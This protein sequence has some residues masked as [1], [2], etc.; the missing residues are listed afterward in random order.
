VLDAR[1]STV[2]EPQWLGVSA[3][4]MG[5]VGIGLL[6]PVAPQLAL[7]GVFAAGFAA[8]ALFNLGAALA[9]FVVLTFFDRTT[10]LQSM[11]LTT[12]VKLGGAVIAAVWLF[13]LLD[14]RTKMRFIFADHPLVAWSAIA[15]VAFAAASMLWATESGAAFSSAF[16]LVQ[17]VLLLVITYSV[18]S[19][20][21]RLS[22]VLGAFVA[23]SLFAAMLGFF[24][25][26]SADASVND[27]RLSGGFDDPNELAAVVVPSMVFCA[28]GFTALGDRLIRWALVPI[29]MLLGVVLLRTDSQAGLV[30]L[31]VALLLALVFSGDL[32]RRAAVVVGTVVVAGTLFYTLV[33]APVAFQTILSPDNTSN[34]ESLWTV[35]GTM[36]SDQP[37]LGVGAG[38]FSVVEPFYTVRAIN[39][40]RV[41]LISEG[42]LV[43]NSYLQVL[44]ELGL[45]GLVAFLGI[46]TSTLV[47]GVRAVRALKRNGDV[48]GE[49]LSRA[50]VIGTAAMLVAYF[51]ATNHY[52]KQLWLMLGTCVA[53]SSVARSSF[54]AGRSFRPDQR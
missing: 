2:S 10:G 16:R 47:V 54:V 15:L 49:R 19:D 8:L 48:E 22:W 6:A 32:R 9:V 17:G 5:A 30:A 26:Y 14:R 31:G 23:G 13:R 34:R 28:Y 36:V 43:H 53:L 12:P 29:A 25:T 42:E 37:L 44:A 1:A 45:L 39:L 35:A 21:K 11:G 38:N 33:T 18:V 24:G 3:L 52:E 46:I 41:D 20:R 50:V 27:A 7:A 4:A 51:F 40:P